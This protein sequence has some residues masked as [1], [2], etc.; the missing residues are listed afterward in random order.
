MFKQSKLAAAVLAAVA[1]SGAQAVHLA[2]DQTGQVLVF[3]YYN[4]NNNF[5]TQISLTNTTDLYK[6]VKIRFRESQDS[7]DTL[8]FNI[9]MSPFDQW[10]AV[11]RRNGNNGKANI[12]TT[13]ETCTYPAK[14]LLQAGVDFIDLYEAVD[15]E[16]TSE[17]YFEVFEMGVIADGDGPADDN[18]EVAEI[19]ED[20]VN[21]GELDGDDDRSIPAGLTHDA[22][23]MPADCS[24][25][26]D[27]WADG[28]PLPAD[29]GGFTRGAMTNGLAS[30]DGAANQPYAG[31][32][33]WG[34]VAP[35]GGLT[36]YSIL[37]NAGNGAAYVADAAIIDNY[38][39]VPQH[40]R[41][42]DPN[43]YLLP[44][45]AS[46]DVAQSMVP[47]SDGTV[48]PVTWQPLSV[49][50][51]DLDDISPNDSIPSGQNPMPIA[52]VL[53]VTGLSND[54]FVEAGDVNGAT[55]WVVTFPMKKHGIFNSEAITDEQDYCDTDGD[56]DGDNDAGTA[57]S[58]PYDD[59]KGAG[60]TEVV[61][62]EN[63]DAQDVEFGFVYYDREEQ[64]YEPEAG[65]PGF[66]PVIDPEDPTFRLTRE[67]NVIVF[68]E[69]GGS[70]SSVLGSP[71]GNDF[72]ITLQPGWDQG[73]MKITFD[74]RY[75]LAQGGGNAPAPLEEAVDI[76]SDIGAPA[77]TAIND[78]F[79]VQGV[80]AIGF[81]AIRGDIGPAAAGETVPHTRYKGA[82]IVAP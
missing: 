52:H 4:T 38:E 22:D 80:P 51:G 29:K 47:N 48:V 71:E 76:N 58:C 24:V 40:Y 5:V 59:L 66:S 63:F 28:G 75:V 1:T 2:E 55:D 67:A 69:A 17:G 10:T 19:N 81:A 57:I 62:N 13:D 39:T 34:L 32:Q 8:D 72:D 77:P 37:L 70:T 56:G 53:A 36:G 15:A 60:R 73:W 9:Y 30:D 61:T 82:D 14:S 23:G 64:F 78:G 27:A 79:D 68:N 21:L 65:A 12:I 50:P 18:D 45:L 11:I 20:G 43:N 26:L 3:P 33:N 46:G 6:A 16:D 42:D 41:S 49:D 31:T 54:Y 7:N 74:S 35:T 25:V 44:S